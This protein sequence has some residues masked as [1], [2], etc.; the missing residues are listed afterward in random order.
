MAHPS[1]DE[2][3]ARRAGMV[4][5]DIAARG[6]GN[7]AV[8]TAM[9]SVPRHRFVADDLADVAYEDRP[10]PIGD[11]QTI[12][13]PYMVAAMVDAAEVGPGDRVLEVG[14]GC[15]YGAAVLGAVARHVWTIE[16]HE[17]LAQRARAT[18]GEL[19]ISNV[20]VGVGDGTKGWSEHAP[21]DAIV[22]TAGG[23]TVPD[24]LL[25]Q[26]SEGG[27]MVIPLGAVTRAQRL[28]R[29]R[30]SDVGTTEEDLGPVSFVPLV[31]GSD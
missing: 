14:T 1:S 11:H 30:K 18:L 26:L 9:S 21:F 3:A 4:A 24:A 25:D 20:T 10:L 22:V 13:Q 7:T 8:L 27:R 31:T 2:F 17:R 12:S 28:I 23:P 19:G 5:H 6:I 16:R 29:V 15:G